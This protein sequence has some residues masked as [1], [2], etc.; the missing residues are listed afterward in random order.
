M[1]VWAGVFA[2][3]GS[4]QLRVSLFI[5]SE[6]KYLK[7]VLCLGVVFAFLTVSCGK[8]EPSAYFADDVQVFRPKP[9]RLPGKLLIDSLMGGSNIE[10]IDGLILL[11]TPQNE[12]LFGVYDVMG[13]PR[14]IFGIRGQGPNDLINCRPVGQK[15]IDNGDACVWIN[16]VSS[17]SLKRVNLSKSTS[18]GQMVIDGVV[19]TYPM[20]LNAFKLNDSTTVCERMD[21]NN[22]SM[23]KYDHNNMEELSRQDVYRIPVSSAF[24]YYK[25]TWRSAPERGIVVGGMHTVNQLNLW[26]LETDERKSVVIDKPLLPGQIVDEKTGLENR[27]FFC[28]VEVTEDFVFALYMDQDYAVSF[29]EP[30]EMTVFVFDWDLSPV[31]AFVLDEYILD[32]AVDPSQKKL[33][34]LCED[35]RIFE[36][37]LS[38]TKKG[39]VQDIYGYRSP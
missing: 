20:S 1:P 2:K 23:I 14:G 22:Y 13:N 32:I 37:D 8:K 25:S 10:T 29:E 35:D 6:M 38:L 39:R 9:E 21:P 36:Y 28:D 15:E 31:A 19:K 11:I 33:Y 16:D 5:L 27:T 12:K 4:P 3:K 18:E 34:G 26:N 30:K 24:S 7:S 17:M